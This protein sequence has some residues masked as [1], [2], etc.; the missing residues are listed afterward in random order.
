MEGWARDL[1]V[2]RYGSREVSYFRPLLFVH[3]MVSQQ[4]YVNMLRRRS[5]W[6][7]RHEWV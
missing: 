6:S 4:V 7:R 1:M 3:L 2:C 5:G